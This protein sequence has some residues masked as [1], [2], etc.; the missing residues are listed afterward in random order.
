MAH[1]GPDGGGS[2]RSASH[3]GWHVSA[4]R[5]SPRKKPSRSV[6]ELKASRATDDT[7]STRFETHCPLVVGERRLTLV[8]LMEPEEGSPSLVLRDDAID[9]LTPGW[10]EVLLEVH[11]DEEETAGTRF[12]HTKIPG[13]QPLHSEAIAAAVLAQ[14]S[15]G[16]QLPAGQRTLWPLRSVEHLSGGMARRW[17]S[18]RG[19]LCQPHRPGLSVPWLPAL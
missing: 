14:I 10:Y 3:R 2:D 5:S 9:F 12:A 18:H 6:R 13:Q 7:P 11:W 8:P 15:Q 17:L 4:S 16:R 1:R 19:Q